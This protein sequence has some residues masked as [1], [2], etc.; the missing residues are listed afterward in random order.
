MSRDQDK[1]N[2]KVPEFKSEYFWAF[3]SLML[4]KVG[5]REAVTTEQLEKFDADEGPEVLYDHDKDAWIMQL[6]AKHRPTIVTVPKK[7][8][9]KTPKI[10][11]S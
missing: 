7:I 4:Y 9:R 5:G 8:L 11:R 1:Q 10:F 2:V 6:Q 3:V